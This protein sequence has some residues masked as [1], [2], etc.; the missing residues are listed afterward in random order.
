MIA[1]FPILQVVLPLMAAPAC[2]LINKHKAA[3][4]FAFIVSALTLLISV[5]L[6]KQV[7]SEGTLVYALGGWDAP[8]GIEYRIDPLNSWV[9]LI[10]CIFNVVALIPAYKSISRELQAEKQ[11][12]FYVLYLLCFAGLLGI[13]ATGDAFNIFVFLEISSLATYALISLGKDRRALLAAYRYLIVGTVG[14]SF[15]LI[16]IGLLYISTGTLNM[17]DLAQRVPA[18]AESKALLAAFIF[19][20]S[21]VCIKLALFPLHAWLP[22]S[23]TWAPSIVAV[24][25]AAT[26]TKVALYLLIRFVFTLFGSELSWSVLPL[27]NIFLVLGVLAVFYASSRAIG[28]LNIKAMFAW[29]SLANIGYLVLG[30]GIGTVAGLQASLL[31]LFNHAFIKGALFLAL[32]AVMYQ[33]GATRFEDFRGLGKRMPWTMFALV[34]SCLSLIGV[35]LT[36]GFISKWYLLLAALDAGLLFVAVLIVVGSLL[37]IVYCWR[38]I[39][40]AYLAPGDVEQNNTGVRQEVSLVFLLPLWLLALANVYFGIDTRLSVGISELTANYLFGLGQFGVGG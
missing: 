34:I 24:F 16:G 22:A 26:A 36:A 20:F 37:T 2:L 31:H 1:H 5:C 39:E 23:Y 11:I 17:Y 4:L 25:L 7:I 21:G 14:A 30:L 9:L 10:V 19:I 6:L 32:A 18:L 3:W 27:Q 38:L 35:P 8:W 12:Y 15:I 13:V 29:S 40:Q 33:L 28:Q